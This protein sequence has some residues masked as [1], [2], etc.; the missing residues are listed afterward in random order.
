MK[1]LFVIF[2]LPFIILG[3]ILIVEIIV[4]VRNANEVRRNGGSVWGNMVNNHKKG[5]R[6]RRNND[7]G[8]IWGDYSYRDPK[9]SEINTWMFN[10]K[11]DNKWVNS[12]EE[13]PYTDYPYLNREC[14]PWVED[15]LNHM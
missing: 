15:Y 12:E 8:V 3:I 14:D 11:E 5:G 6:K 13:E 9:G 4:A 7:T 10:N 2:V 1:V